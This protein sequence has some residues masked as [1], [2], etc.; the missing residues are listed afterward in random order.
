MN[1]SKNFGTKDLNRHFSE[2]DIQRADIWK[3][4]QQKTLERIQ[5]IRF[6]GTGRASGVIWS[7]IPTNAIISSTTYLVGSCVSLFPKKGSSSLLP[8]ARHSFAWIARV[9]AKF[10]QILLPCILASLKVSVI[11]RGDN[12]AQ[13]GQWFLNIFFLV[14]KSSVTIDFSLEL[15]TIKLPVCWSKQMFI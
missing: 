11:A 7:N 15:W 5:N 9:V 3:I 13:A 8:K 1:G 6:S 2:E 4:A 10:G 14:W 12:R